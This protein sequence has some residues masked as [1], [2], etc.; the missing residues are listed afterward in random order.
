[1]DFVRE[2]PDPRTWSER[3]VETSR[4]RHPADGAPRLLCSWPR[5]YGI[6]SFARTLVVKGGTSAESGAAEVTVT[7]DG[8]RP[9]PVRPGAQLTNPARLAPEEEWRGWEVIIDAEEWEPGPHVVTV[10]ASDERGR[11]TTLQRF[12]Q[13]DR[14]GLYASWRSRRDPARWRELARDPMI[15]QGLPRIAVLL[16]HGDEGPARTAEDRG[17][18]EVP[19]AHDLLDVHLHAVSGTA[20]ALESLLGGEADY[21]VLVRAG[22]V[23]EPDALLGIAVTAALTG[24]PDLVYADHDLI[25]GLGRRSSPRFKPQWSPELL[26][27]TDYVGPFVALGRDAARAALAAEGAPPSAIYEV[28]LRLLEADPHV[29]RV[30]DVLVSLADSDPPDDEHEAELVRAAVRR[31][32]SSGDVRPLGPGRRRVT[33]EP[34]AWPK[35]SAVIT[36][37]LREDLLV[38]L[39]ASMHEH[40]SYEQLEIVVV[41][42]GEGDLELARPWLEG[43]EHRIIRA[44]RPFNYSAANNI[45]A[46]AA[47]GEYLLFLNDDVEV[48][49]PRWIERLVGQVQQ[50]GVGKVGV[51][52]VYPS[53]HV[54]HGGVL[55][56]S[57]SEPPRT[58]LHLHAPGTGGSEHLLELARNSA[59]VGTA[60]AIVSARFFWD[61][62]GFDEDLV[63]AFN[64]IDLSLR[65]WNAGRRVVWTP[66]VIL[67]HHCRASRGD[68]PWPADLERFQRR[69]EPLLRSGDPFFNP[70]LKISPE[71][72]I[73]DSAPDVEQLRRSLEHSPGRPPW[74]PTM[75][76]TPTALASVRR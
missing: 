32:G 4:A 16:Q 49:T 34:T 63:M 31:R 36:T 52:L 72:E 58:Q 67:T 68:A 25:D 39:L 27:S 73:A 57:P 53:G 21:G 12:V 45:G 65:V 59:A 42:S 76:T 3:A 11:T 8:G 26:L 28:L 10:A 14:E 13:H 24:Y 62:G 7:V 50:P 61:L 64:D 40:T 17:L 46:K 38:K 2:D 20:E 37:G 48:L 66:E 69:W 71:H 41:N 22:D 23:L 18:R 33:W 51:K 74:R 43:L 35:V 47:T 75:V 30:P 1:M 19:A 15:A 56:G 60:C 9:Y 5:W 54:E 55:L 6:E 44:P 70:N 29:E